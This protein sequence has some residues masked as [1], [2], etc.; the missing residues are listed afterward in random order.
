MHTSTSCAILTTEL[1]RWYN[2]MAPSWKPKLARFSAKQKIQDG[3]QS[4]K[5]ETQDGAQLTTVPLL[6]S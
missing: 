6:T 3:A 5:A 2:F 4:T 1:I